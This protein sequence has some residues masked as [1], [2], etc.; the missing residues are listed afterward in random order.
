MSAS[1]T[2]LATLGLAFVASAQAVP[3]VFDSISSSS[4]AQ[5]DAG[6]ASDGP[7]SEVGDGSL[8]LVSSAAASSAD[9]DSASANAF[10]ESLFLTTSS[11]VSA[12]PGNAS[13]NAVSTFTGSFNALPGRLTL[14]LDFDAFIDQLA[15]GLGSNALAVTL[16]ID[17]V[18]LYSDLLSA[19]T[20]FDH[21]ILLASGGMGL[22]DLT[23]VS[24]TLAAPGD[25]AFSLGSVNVALDATSVPEPGGMALLAAGLLGLAWVRRKPVRA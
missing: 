11:E 6:D 5:A 12:L 13:G 24:T 8:P 25:Y 15:T 16:E 3:I 22:L 4:F 7:F 1:H 9:G 19:S 10:A 18:T 23:L 14:S 21:S 2:L 17:G 20:A